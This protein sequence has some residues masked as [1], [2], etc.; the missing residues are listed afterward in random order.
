LKIYRTTWED[1]SITF[2][3]SKDNKQL[4][5]QLDYV[6]ELSSVFSIEELNSK[7]GLVVEC[8]PTHDENDGE[9]Y[10]ETYLH[11]NEIIEDK[12]NLVSVSIDE[13]PES[14]RKIF[15]KNLSKTI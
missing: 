11:N 12:A 5:L 8:T 4:L 1:G 9:L 10:Y 14:F 7:N 2:T 3:A 6:G 15:Y 13:L